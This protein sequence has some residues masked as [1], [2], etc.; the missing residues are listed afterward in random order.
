MASFKDPDAHL[1]ITPEEEKITNEWFDSLSGKDGA[2]LLK[3]SLQELDNIEE[4]R[5]KLSKI[6]IHKIY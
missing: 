5:K 6:D 4:L 2:T 1:A 3:E